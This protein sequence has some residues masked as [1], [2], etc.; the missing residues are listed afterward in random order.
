M[1][2]LAGGDVEI[3]TSSCSLE[4]VHIMIYVKK[5]RFMEVCWVRTTTERDHYQPNTVHGLDK[6][7]KYLSKYGYI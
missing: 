1:G 6:S 7:T 3:T 5:Y 4:W 2:F